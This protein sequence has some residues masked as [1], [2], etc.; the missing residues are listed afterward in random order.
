MI[1]IFP[2]DKR[3]SFIQGHTSDNN[4]SLLVNIR[5]V[6]FFSPRYHQNRF[7]DLCFSY[8]TAHS[9]NNSNNKK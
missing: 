2:Y 9:L 1:V 6:D 4:G 5:A 8:V 3:I 7:K